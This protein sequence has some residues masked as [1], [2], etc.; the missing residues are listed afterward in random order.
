MPT[1][2][3]RAIQTMLVRQGGL[4]LLLGFVAGFGFLFFLIGAIELWPIPGKID[5]QLP[6]TV[7]AWRMS[8][9]EG[10]MNGLML[11]L[12]AAVL[13]TFALPFATAR[14]IAHMLVVTAWTFP[15]AS[16]FDAFFQNSRGLRFGGPVT[17]LIPFFLFYIGIILLVWA[18]IEIIIKVG[19]GTT[20]TD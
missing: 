9:L 4:V 15:I 10:V 6:G 2:D 19:R 1:T 3:Y 5:Y 17:N 18:V 20:P 14:R 8:H 12:L 7:K 13:P 16:L 11:W